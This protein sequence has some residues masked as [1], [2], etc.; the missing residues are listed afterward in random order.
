MDLGI[1]LWAALVTMLCTMEIPM[2]PPMVRMAAV[3]AT[4]V[5]MRSCGLERS[6]DS[7]AWG[8]TP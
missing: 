6:L 1:F 7:F 5:P 2:A 4:A 3:S 8:N